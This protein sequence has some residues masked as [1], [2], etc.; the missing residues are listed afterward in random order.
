MCEKRALSREAAP[1]DGSHTPRAEVGMKKGGRLRDP[2]WQIRY[3]M[4]PRHA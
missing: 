4:Q 3:E 1:D 2:C